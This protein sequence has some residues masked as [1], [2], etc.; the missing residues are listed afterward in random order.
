MRNLEIHAHLV[1][2]T[3]SAIGEN[4]VRFG[5]NSTKKKQYGD[6]VYMASSVCHC[7]YCLDS[8]VCCPRNSHRDH[9]TIQQPIGSHGYTRH[10]PFCPTS[11]RVFGQYSKECGYLFYHDWWFIIRFR[12]RC[13][14]NSQK[15]RCDK[16]IINFLCG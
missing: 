11:P 13:V 5:R 12:S 9:V 4:K 8:F 16:S 7:W 3:S 14:G 6:H 10:S 1:K 15:S 2:Q